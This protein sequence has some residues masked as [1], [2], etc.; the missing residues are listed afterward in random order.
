MDGEQQ[1]LKI[2]SV[3]PYPPPYSGWSAAIR[4]EIHALQDAGVECAILN[5]APNRN[6]ENAVGIGFNNAFEYLAALLRHAWR[7]FDFRLHVNGDSINGVL[8]VIAAQWIALILGRR[9]AL[10]FHAGADQQFFPDRGNLFLKLLWML[11]FNSSRVVICNSEEVAELIRE[12]KHSA[13]RVFAIPAFSSRRMLSQP[14]DFD[15]GTESFLLRHQPLFFA[16][17]AY[18]PEYSLP[19]FF[20]VVDRLHEAFPQAGFIMV[21]D[22]TY[23]VPE[24]RDA[25]ETWYVRSRFSSAILRTGNI[26]HDRFVSLLGRSTVYLRPHLRDGVASSVLEALALGVPVVAADNGF[27]PET[28]LTYPPDRPEDMFELAVRAVN[29]E[30]VAG[31]GAISEATDRDTVAEL[32]MVLLATFPARG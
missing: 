2:L 6:D 25:M 24:V 13:E 21:D 19:E 16:Y 14:V 1:K 8:M 26:D 31:S 18:R 27:R 28:V 30:P 5:T 3:G 7:G 10:T 17:F 12:Y 15:E 20:A 32:V 4:E 22:R 29:M 9:S 23:C 11:I